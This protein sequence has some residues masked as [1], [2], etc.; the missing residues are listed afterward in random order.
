MVQEPISFGQL[1]IESNGLLTFHL[2]RLTGLVRPNSE[3]SYALTDE[4]REALRMIEASRV[5]HLE[6]NPPRTF[7][8][9][10]ERKAVVVGLA[11][12]IV[13]LITVG[14][15]LGNAYLNNTNT[16]SSLNS[17]NSN[18]EAYSG[19][20]NATIT[21]SLSVTVFAMVRGENT[22]ARL[23]FVTVTVIVVSFDSGPNV[24]VARRVMVAV[25]VGFANVAIVYGIIQLT[26]AVAG[27]PATVLN[28]APVG[29]V[30]EVIVGISPKSGSV[31]V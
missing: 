5:S 28:V 12:L 20:A 8:H 23:T 6:T 27:L 4:G 15:L 3:G 7:L 21:V 2:G 26:V 11:L 18:L 22:G 24:S 31:D 30:T 16:I 29:K 17:R 10:P 9:L 25:A 19:A 13:G 1:G 14:A